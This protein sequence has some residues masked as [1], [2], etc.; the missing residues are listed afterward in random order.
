MLPEKLFDSTSL[1]TALIILSYNNTEIRLVE[2]RNV[3][4]KGRR[5]NTFSGNDIERIIEAVNVDR[6]ISYTVSI[7]DFGKYGYDLNPARFLRIP[8]SIEN[9]VELR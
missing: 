3:Y 8:E 7:N 2:A 1:A 5:Q 6:D 4:Q 9:G